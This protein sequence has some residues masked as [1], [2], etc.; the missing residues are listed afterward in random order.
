LKHGHGEFFLYNK[1]YSEFFP[2]KRIIGL[3]VLQDQKNHRALSSATSLGTVPARVARYYLTSRQRRRARYDVSTG[4]KNRTQATEV[5]SFFRARKGRAYGFRF[6]DWSDYRVIGQ[7]IGAGNGTQTAFQLTKTY[8]SGGENETRPLK[9]PVSGT[10]KL[11][12]DGVLQSSGVA[13]DHTTGMVTFTVAPAAGVLI[14]ADCEFDVPV[15]FDTDRLAIRIQSHELFVWDQI[16]L[17]EI[18]I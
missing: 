16:P 7:L 2:Q 13:V 3:K 14:T 15:R 6:K 8:T 17:V 1:C 10:V 18:R 4:I 9:K 11:Y 5:I 12:K